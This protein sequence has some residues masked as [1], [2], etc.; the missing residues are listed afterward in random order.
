MRNDKVRAGSSIPVADFAYDRKWIMRSTLFLAMAVIWVM[1]LIVFLL[2]F[3]PLVA[4]VMGLA[5]GVFFLV[6]GVSPFLTKHSIDADG[7]VLRQGWHFKVRIPI[8]KV[9]AINLI[10]LAPKDRSLFISQ[11]RGIL[12]ITSKKR[13]LVSIKLRRRQRFA[14]VFWRRADEIIFD[15]ADREGFRSEF[16]NA[17]VTTHA[18]PALSSSI[19]P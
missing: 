9:K 10:D 16:E 5:M 12:N 3:D 14:V 7:I 1:V 8:D 18:S 15:V 13:E 17:L 11:T 2:P 19:R 4:V 6:V